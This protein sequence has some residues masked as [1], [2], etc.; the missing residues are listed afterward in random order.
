MA[1][2][3]G[4]LPRASADCADLEPWL[5]HG[6][7]ADA[8]VRT[9]QGEIRVHRV[10]LAS[11]SPYFSRAFGRGATAVDWSAPTLSRAADSVLARIY[12]GGQAKPP[13]PRPAWTGAEAEA[14]ARTWHLVCGQSDRDVVPTDRAEPANPAEPVEHAD[15]ARNRALRGPCVCAWRRDPCPPAVVAAFDAHVR[16]TVP[17]TGDSLTAER[18]ADWAHLVHCAPDFA[19]PLQRH[20]LRVIDAEAQRLAAD[21][22]CDQDRARLLA[23]QLHALLK[24]SAPR[25]LES[26][27]A[28]WFREAVL[29]QL[30]RVWLSDRPADLRVPALERG[31]EVHA[32]RLLRASGWDASDLVETR[33]EPAMCALVGVLRRRLRRALGLGMGRADDPPAPAGAADSSW[34]VRMADALAAFAQGTLW[35]RLERSL[36]IALGRPP[37]PAPRPAPRPGV[38]DTRPFARFRA[39]P[40]RPSPAFTTSGCLPPPPPAPLPVDRGPVVRRRAIGSCAAARPGYSCGTRNT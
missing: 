12:A 33:S 18:L 24:Q 17:A 11:R 14:H 16:A 6:A 8:V 21:R 26:L 25:S 32:A 31:L 30:L 13:R 37:P 28:G 38:R 5:R 27:S 15:R 7:L 3:E 19:A 40:R 36:A 29:V 34:H 10:V 22:L 4:P 23:G 1:R 39:A 35:P 9:A 2:V 20:V